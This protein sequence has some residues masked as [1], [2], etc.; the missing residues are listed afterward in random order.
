M[1]RGGGYIPNVSEAANDRGR[2]NE[3]GCEGAVGGPLESWTINGQESE[4]CFA[5]GS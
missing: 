5:I 1:D 2:G 4:S 3:R